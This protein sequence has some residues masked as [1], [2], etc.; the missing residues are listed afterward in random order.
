VAERVVTDRQVLIDLLLKR[1]DNYRVG[2]R[3]S[4][5]SK[6][7][8]EGA[9]QGHIL[10]LMILEDNRL[11]GREAAGEVELRRSL[12]S[13]QRRLGDRYRAFLR[14]FELTEADV[15]EKLSQHIV[16]DSILETR[17]KGAGAELESRSAGKKVSAADRE[18]AGRKALEDW[19]LQLKA[20][21]RVQ[22]LN[23]D[24]ALENVAPTAKAGSTP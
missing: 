11:V 8:L 1:P 24:R 2:L 12:Q 20:R 4:D 15:R 9:T 17:V 13:L 21:Y 16:V 19:V 14:D 3:P 10:E 6:T 23:V 22:R 18:A 7:L 5:L